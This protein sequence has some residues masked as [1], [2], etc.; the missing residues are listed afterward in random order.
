MSKIAKGFKAL[1]GVLV[2]DVKSKSINR[3]MI[4][5]GDI[6]FVIDA[7]IVDGLPIMSCAQLHD[8]AGKAVKRKVRSELLDEPPWPWPS[9]SKE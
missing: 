7:E 3:V 6:A 1:K 4:Y 9:I 2:T 5:S 8:K